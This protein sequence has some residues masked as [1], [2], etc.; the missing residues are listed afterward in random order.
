MVLLGMVVNSKLFNKILSIDVYDFSDGF[1]GW[2]I[3]G[4]DKHIVLQNWEL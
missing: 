3:S 4:K 1:T 2:W